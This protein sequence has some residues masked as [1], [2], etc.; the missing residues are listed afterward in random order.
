M[1]AEQEEEVRVRVK[2]ELEVELD[3]LA[4]KSVLKSCRQV[5]PLRDTIN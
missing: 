3:K 1:E 2:L 5:C 4:E